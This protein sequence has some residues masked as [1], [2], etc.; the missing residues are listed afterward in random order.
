[1]SRQEIE[2][3]VG[4]ETRAWD[5]QD[6][7]LLMSVLHPDMVWPW[8]ADQGSLDPMTW[9]LELGRYDYSRWR[10]G[11]QELFDTHTLIHN[12]RRII[13]IELSR[14]GDGALAIVD[15]DTLWRAADG[16]DNHWSGRTCKIYTRVGG[17][18]RM[19]T[20]LGTFAPPTVAE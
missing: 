8:P 16:S 6:V 18:W 13:R 11:W 1:M 19:I 14:E 5:T 3:I 4:R 9:I 2:E 17:E 12:R 7:D 20:Q 10:A 15:I